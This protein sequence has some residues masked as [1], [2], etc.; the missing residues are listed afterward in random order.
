MIIIDLSHI[1]NP[2]A[3]VSWKSHIKDGHEFELDFKSRVLGC[4]LNVLQT[5]HDDPYEEVIL[6][7]DSRNNW[8]RDYFK[9]YK[10]RRALTRVKEDIDWDVVHKV[11][12]ELIEELKDNFF[13]KVIQEHRTEGDD[14]VCVLCRYKA[15]KERI[16]L[17]GI[18]K[19]YY[20]LHDIDDLTQVTYKGKPCECDID[21]V[22]YKKIQVMIGDAGDDVP[23]VLNDDDAY[24]NKDKKRI[25]FG[26]KGAQKLIENG[27]VT[28]KDQEYTLSE[29][30][31]SDKMQR[32]MMMVNADCIPQEY[33]D[34]I[35]AQ[36]LDYEVAGSLEK[37]DRYFNSKCDVG[38]NRF[39]SNI[40]QF[41]IKGLKMKPQR[42]YFSFLRKKYSD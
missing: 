33:Q 19:D 20:Q 28:I 40:S 42:D 35:L 13:F 41:I 11:E 3:R 6:A 12:D 32:N 25:P 4:I 8:R 21:P 31:E 30:V 24:L 38:H 17:V 15:G 26:P 14:V 34:R 27:S 39:R 22:L 29:I 2:M 1:T 23:N 36:Y 9:E 7:V 37:L 18:D 5:Y 10:G 16:L